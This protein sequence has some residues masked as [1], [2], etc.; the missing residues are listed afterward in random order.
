MEE[1]G[2]DINLAEFSVTYILA[3]LAG[4]RRDEEQLA[5]DEIIV[6]LWIIF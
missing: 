6:R 3:W 1:E 4:F 5:L 2:G